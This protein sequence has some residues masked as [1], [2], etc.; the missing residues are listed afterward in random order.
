MEHK[1]ELPSVPLLSLVPSLHNVRRHTAEQVEE[2]AA[3]IDAQ[4]LLHNLTVIEHMVGRGKARELR[5]A[6]AGGEWRRQALLLLQQRGRVPKAHEVLYELVAPERALEL[7]VAENSGREAPGRRV[8][9]LQ[10]LDTT[11]ATASRTW[12]RASGKSVLAVQRRLKLSAVSP[13]LL[14]LY[15]QDGINLDQLMALTLTDEHKARERTWF[16]AQ[17]WDRTPAALRRVF[18]AGEVE[19]AG[20]AQATR[21]NPLSCVRSE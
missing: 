5:F 11:R 6:V 8:R 12:R 10:G 19:A 18:T 4:G 3:L 15:R 13:K 7:S 14:A 2:L 1:K 16:D 21:L 17:P 20:S 9:G